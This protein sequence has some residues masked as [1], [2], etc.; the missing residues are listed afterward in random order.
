[1]STRGSFGGGNPTGAAGGDLSGAYP[2]PTV[3][4]TNLSS[5]MPLTQGGTGSTTQ[6]FIDL[7]TNQNIAGAKT[8]TDRIIVPTPTSGTDA[9]SKGYADG[10]SAGV[11]VKASVAAGTNTALPANLYVN[12]A[13]GVGATLT[14]TTNGVLVVDGYTVLLGDRILVK[15]EAA[16][17]NNGIYTVTTL[18]TAGIPY[19]LTRAIDLDQASEIPG[20]AA[21]I[22]N[23]TI[24]QGSGWVVVGA[25]PYT[26]G[27]TA[28]LF[29]QFTSPGLVNVGLGLR[30]T[31]NT[32]SLETPVDPSNLPEATT[33]AKGVI[34]LTNDLG[35][36]AV[37]PTVT[38]TH[39]ASPLPLAQGG[40]AATTAAGA[41]TTLALGNSATANI[42][43]TGANIAPLGTQS[44]GAVGSVADAG[45]I[46][47]MPTLNQINAP[48]TAVAMSAQ[49]ITG[50]A[51][52]TAATDGAAFG[53]IPT[54]LP[55]SGAATGDL[56]GTYPAP[57]LSN[58]ANVQSV[59]RSNRL[60]QM[61]APTAAV[62]LNSQKI[63]NLANGTA[64]T[65][66]AAFG[67]VPTTF[68]P[69]GAAG[70]DLSSTYPNPTVAKVNGITI[71]GTPATGQL[72]SATSTS[73]ASWQNPT[74]GGDLS[75]TLPNPTVA[76]VNGVAVT[77]TAAYGARP[78]ATSSSAAAWNILPTFASS[79]IYDGGGVMTQN[80][81]ILNAFDITAA[82]GYIVDYHT[83][84]TVPV[85]TP[86]S[87]SSQTV[88][89]SG[90]QLSQTVNY[91][92]ANSSG[93]ILSQTTPLTG[94]QRRA[95][96]LL[97]VTWGATG[98]GNL[99]NIMSAPIVLPYD[100]DTL[101]GLFL[102]MG[103]FSVS[104]NKISANGANL[105][106]NKTAG[107]QIAAGYNYG[108]GG[109]QTPNL[110][111]NPV[112]TAATFR[113][114]TQNTSSQSATRTTVD[115]ANYDVGGTITALT[116]NANA[117]IHR[118]WLVPTGTATSQ[119]V[120]QYGQVL[121]ANLAAANAAIG[122]ETYVINPDLVG[123]QAT[124]LGYITAVKNATQLNNVAQA[125]F[126]NVGRFDNA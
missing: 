110:V 33:V 108:S 66:A 77:G 29:T 101:W 121:Y 57:T 72:I 59:V 61:A 20:A 62:N 3:T 123:S 76:K 39:L 30:I 78:T 118:V 56:T 64:A 42:N 21:F 98:T 116:V 17:A 85:I 50:L 74:V 28:I 9:V 10:I 1:M 94:L 93:T 83:T 4:H 70:G 124:L 87:I 69:S 16:G 81:S 2:T 115:V 22:N 86:V 114:V 90:G 119:I 96:I 104:G 54:T 95:N 46:H 112:A 27:T 52:G 106:I 122:Q 24:N 125:Q 117:A 91:W 35:G 88:T 84:P 11:V 111:T 34:E 53:Q 40:V 109:V 12:G 99:Y 73:A 44:A 113:Y 63:T 47:A 51:N 8:F 89:L 105:N 15:N 41:R 71:T 97:G 67:Q 31:G 7:T 107:T 5:P 49:K 65:D 80:G 55:P 38:A 13:L 79:G 75:G 103:S 37:L 48:T 100:T 18:G 26:L 32:I 102:N 14:A 25:G 19:A 6:N 45:H 23:G 126:F 92:Y 43:S 68:P 60:D 58:T 82:S 120:I 36:T